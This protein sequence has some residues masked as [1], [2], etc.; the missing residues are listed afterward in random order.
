MTKIESSKSWDEKSKSYT[1]TFKK[2]ADDGKTSVFQV[3]DYDND[4]LDSHDGLIFNGDSSLWS[5]EEI[6][7]EL[8]TYQE[9]SL[10]TT[11]KN[12]KD[13][14][15]ADVETDKDGKATTQQGKEYNLGS[16]ARANGLKGTNNSSNSANSSG[17]PSV[18]N[19]F[20]SLQGG[21]PPFM[22]GNSFPGAMPMINIDPNAYKAFMDKYTNI[23]SAITLPGLIGGNDSSIYLM[24]SLVGPMLQEAMGLFTKSQIT[25]NNTNTANNETKSNNQE[26]KKDETVKS[27]NSETKDNVI[28][29]AENKESALKGTK[30]HEG[31]FVGVNEADETIK[32]YTNDAGNRVCEVYDE[33]GKLLRVNEYGEEF[34]TRTHYDSNGKVINIEYVDKKN[35]DS[36]IKNETGKAIETKH[37]SLKQIELENLKKQLLNAQG[38]REKCSLSIRIKNLQNEIKEEEINKI[39]DTIKIKNKKQELTK[40]KA[41]YKVALANNDGRKISALSQN[42]RRLESEIK[43]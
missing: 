15:L 1:Y 39:I 8:Q 27:D 12:N 37:A 24:P 10:A 30:Y 35:I 17:F 20:D 32:K 23:L 3:T 33:N 22:G 43:E 41:E 2:T 29:P 31:E 26:T 13:V 21:F 42:I 11:L 28:T 19:P 36:K 6:N 5:K 14:T 40:L 7:K 25:L 9:S 4:G 38:G 16:F 18:T 34:I